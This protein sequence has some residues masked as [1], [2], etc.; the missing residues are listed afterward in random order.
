MHFTTALDNASQPASSQAR[1]AM[2]KTLEDAVGQI[3]SLSSEQPNSEEAL[4]VR[5][6]AV[7]AARTCKS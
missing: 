1:P 7:G 3:L 2:S 4:E 5:K 6:G